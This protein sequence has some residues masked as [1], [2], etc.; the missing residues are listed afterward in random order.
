MKPWRNNQGFG[1]LEH[2]KNHPQF[3]VDTTQVIQ[4]IHEA[5]I[6]SLKNGVLGCDWQGLVVIEFS[7]FQVANAFVVMKLVT[8]SH[9]STLHPR[10]FSNNS[11]SR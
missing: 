11:I 4:V 5:A 1:Y 10:M 9:N 2:Q 6:G 7:F 8:L 3:S